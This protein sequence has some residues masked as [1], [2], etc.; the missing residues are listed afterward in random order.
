MKKIFILAILSAF[1]IGCGNS[2]PEVSE[3]PIDK[4]NTTIASK[5]KPETV[6]AHTLDKEK[7]AKAIPTSDPNK[8]PMVKKSNEKTSWTRSG[9]PI[10]TTKFD[11]DVEKAEKELKAKPNDETTK[12]NLS[13]AYTKRGVALTEA[14]QYAAAIGDYRKAL[15][16]DSD[17]AEAKKWIG[18]ITNIYKSM[19]REVPK[20]G[21]EPKP[22]EFKGK[23][24]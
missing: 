16:Y 11:A 13:E 1:L 8:P 21:E 20:E 12:K 9:D 4:K 6:A 24:S 15:K 2:A 19:N 7:D 5:D 23:K 14:R 3:Q 10:D 18:T 17:N 22:L